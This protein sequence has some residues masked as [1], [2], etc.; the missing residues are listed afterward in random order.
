MHSEGATSSF[1]NQEEQASEE[2]ACP[3]QQGTQYLDLYEKLRPQTSIANSPYTSAAHLLDLAHLTLQEALLAKA[4]TLLK[5][6]R[7]DYATIPLV[8]AFN[9]SEVFSSVREFSRFENV[10]WKRQTFFIVVFR[11][12]L[13]STTDRSHL[14]KL[15]QT[16]HIEAGR[17]GGLLKYWFGEPDAL[18]RNL[19]T[20]ETVLLR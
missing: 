6:L 5:Q 4:L 13:P 19:A 20:C 2:I 16:S 9:W 15:D 3:T 7:S 17:S 11:S 10:T 8:D 12:R 18:G 1:L 14:S